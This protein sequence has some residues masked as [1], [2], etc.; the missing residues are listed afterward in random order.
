M[1]CALPYVSE[2]VIHSTGSKR[3]RLSQKWLRTR[4][5]VNSDSATPSCAADPTREGSHPPGSS[6]QR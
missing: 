6:S 2:R 1:V 4:G 5:R 3:K